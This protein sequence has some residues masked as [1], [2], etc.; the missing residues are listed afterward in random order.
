MTKK[1]LLAMLSFS[2]MVGSAQASKLVV[3]GINL[4]GPAPAGQKVYTIGMDTQG[5]GGSLALGNITFVGA[6]PGGN[7]LQS[8]FNGAPVFP[9]PE[10]NPD[11]KQSAFDL[12]NLG[13]PEFTQ[14]DSWFYA[15]SSG[16]LINAKGKV[17]TTDP[18]VGPT[19]QLWFPQATGIQGGQGAAPDFGSGTDFSITATYGTFPSFVPAGIYPVAQI[20]TS[21]DV[22]IG[23]GPGTKLS[24]QP[25]GGAE[26]ATNVLNGDQLADPQAVLC[27]GQDAVV[28]LSAC[29]P[30]PSSLVLA[31]LG[32]VALAGL[33]RRR[34][35]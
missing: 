31:G 20:R 14:Y 8:N 4:N 34:R 12:G 11:S 5:V 15:G 17:V 13:E 24:V 2:I 1:V 30:E 26:V 16:Q 33:A 21:G 23:F 28:T 22:R 19:G 29:V 10:D 25:A 18:I 27:F 6:G 3:L 7:P 32:L 35:K 9:F